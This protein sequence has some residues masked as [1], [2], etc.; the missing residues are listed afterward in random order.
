MLQALGLGAAEGVVYTALLPR[1]SA[2]AQDLA[3]QTGLER[4]EIARVGPRGPVR[5]P[6]RPCG[7]APPGASRLVDTATQGAQQAP[8][9][10]RLVVVVEHHVSAGPRLCHH[11]VLGHTGRPSQAM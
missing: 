7:A 8:D 5:S 2:S 1:P 6:T 11:Q 4:A 9:E 10:T 3:R